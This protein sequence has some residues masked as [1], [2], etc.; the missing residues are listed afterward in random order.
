MIRLIAAVLIP[1][2]LIFSAGCDF[3]SSPSK[4]TLVVYS[5]VEPE[6]T[7]AL[8]A[9]YNEQFKTM[10]D[11]QEVSAVY[12]LNDKEK[13]DLVLAGSRTLTGLKA[14]KRLQQSS[15]KPAET[16]PLDF[17]D[18]DG[19]WTGVFYDPVVF[20]INQSFARRVGQSNLRGWNDL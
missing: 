2:M 7:E 1:F 12:E 18:V 17:K 14:D 6:L 11:F 19:Y 13:P 9:T 4:K 15:F 5:E 3:G 20:V 8:L 10:K 16:L